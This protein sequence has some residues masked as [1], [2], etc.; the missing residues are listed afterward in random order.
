[1]HY[2]ITTFW[3]RIFAFALD[4]AILGIT[5]FLL[6][7]PLNG[8]FVSLGNEGIFVGFFISLLYFTI[9]NSNLAKGQTLG[10]RFLKIQSLDKN[11]NYLSISKSLVRTLILIIPFFFVN[12]QYPFL[13]PYSIV[14][15]IISLFFFNCIIFIIVFYIFNKSSRQGL[16]DL[17]INSIVA[18]T[19]RNEEPQEIK[20]ANTSAFLYASAFVVFFI[21][22]AIFTGSRIK[23]NFPELNPIVQKLSE[24][25]EVINASA[26]KGIKTTYLNKEKT[27]YKFLT[28]DLSVSDLP[29]PNAS[30][31][32]PE[33]VLRAVEN[34]I[35]ISPDINKP[36]SININLIKQYNIGI[37]KSLRSVSY[38]KT[39]E[40]WTA[41]LQNAED[42]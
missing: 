29:S 26:K 39:K 32:T 30:A 21:G 15:T 18:N 13:P 20:K 14:S 22:I 35:T 2:S 38:S 40:E 37:A 10:K 17:A 12:Y 8:F 42:K 27:Q 23:Q 9:M 25:K 24:D 33:T 1:M 4:S 31:K 6:A 19:F 7:I 11:G 16:H 34:V 3:V 36:D 28:I 5:G 41:M